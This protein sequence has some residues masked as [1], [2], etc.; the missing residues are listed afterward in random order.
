MELPII[1]PAQMPLPPSEVRLRSIDVQPYPDRRRLKVRLELTPFQV[2]PDIELALKDEQGGYLASASIIGAISNIMTLTLHM[3]AEPRSQHCT[4][5]ASL[6]YNEL[7]T[8]H[9]ETVAFSVTGA[10]AAEED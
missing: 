6:A 4:V 10:S 7:G 1:D 8:V 9:T 2:A 3:R 5:E